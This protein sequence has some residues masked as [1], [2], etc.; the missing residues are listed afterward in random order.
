MTNLAKLAHEL[1]AQAAAERGHDWVFT[2]R[3]GEPPV[4][5]GVCQRRRCGWRWFDSTPE[6]KGCRGAE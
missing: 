3:S 4:K 5:L 2:E 1:H 6:P